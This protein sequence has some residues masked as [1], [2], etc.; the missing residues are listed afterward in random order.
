[1]VCISSTLSGQHPICVS[2]VNAVSQDS[3]VDYVLKLT[4]RRPVVVNGVTTRIASRQALHPGNIIAGDYLKETCERYGFIAEDIP[5]SSSGRNIVMYKNGTVNNKE[6]YI[7]CAHYD[8]VGNATIDFQGADDNASG[9]AALL[10]AARV[11]QS[12]TFP[13]TIVLAFWDEEE[14]GLIG[15]RAFAPDGPLGYWNVKGVINLDMIGYDG[16]GDSL[17]L[18]HVKPIGNSLSLGAKLI[19][20]NAKFKT[21][22]QTRMRNPGEEAT[23]QQSFWLKGVTTVG[24]TE[25][26]DF[27]FSPHWHL[28]S[29]SIENMHIPYFTKM[30]TL[31]IGA[32][33]EI[34]QTGNL[35]S[36]SETFPNL[37]MLYPNPVENEL[38]LSFSKPV[39]QAKVTIYNLLGRQVH[40]SSHS[41]VSFTIETSNLQ[42]G[43]YMVH[44]QDSN[45]ILALEKFAKH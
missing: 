21:G 45:G 8:C 9:S 3:L 41:G 32:I 26:Y 35:V 39:T 5:Y 38:I 13:Y 16:N 27:D 34:S 33:C 22:L 23:D 29:D 6:A 40:Q 24:F 11:L 7:L 30:A 15:S 1:L 18:I 25:D 14:N 28:R 42:Q 43:Q 36:T 37:F 4:G 12:A 17:G 2:A 19:D 20:L 10:E 44:I 31:T